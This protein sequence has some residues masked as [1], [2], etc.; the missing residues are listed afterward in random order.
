MMSN[1]LEDS[2]FTLYYVTN[3]LGLKIFQLK[4]SLKNIPTKGLR[5]SQRSIFIFRRDFRIFDNKESIKNQNFIP[6]R[7]GRSFYSFWSVDHR[8]RRHGSYWFSY[9]QQSLYA[10]CKNSASV[11]PLFVF[12]PEQVTA[13]EFKSS[14]CVQF[15]V[16]SLKDLQ[17]QLNGNLN[18]LY[19]NL[20]DILNDIL[21]QVF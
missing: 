2:R 6:G 19:G 16:E 3:E 7:P 20:F 9:Q 5:M 8:V 15:M 1:S 4:K 17:N 18:L 14:N 21:R 12:T 11:I 13:N 10:A